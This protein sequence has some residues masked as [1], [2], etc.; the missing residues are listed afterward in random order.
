MHVK[1]TLAPLLTAALAACTVADRGEVA[2]ADVAAARGGHPLSCAS[3]TTLHALATCIGAQM[4]QA[5]SNGFVV[6]TSAQQADFAGVVARM[7]QGS[8]SFTLPASLAGT[9]QLRPFTDHGNGTTYCLFMEVADADDDGYVDR[10][11]GTFIVDP[12]A[13]RELSHQAAHPLSDIGTELQAI[14]IF[15]ETASRSYLMCGADRFA[16]AAASPCEPEAA[17]GNADCAHNTANMFYPATRAIA[18]HYGSQANVQIQWHGIA[19][20]TCP[21]D[22]AY[23]SPGLRTAPATSSNVRTLRASALSFNPSWVLGLSGDGTCDMDGSD[24]TEGRPLN[25][26]PSGSACTTF[27]SSASDAFI[28]I[29][30]HPALRVAASWVPAILEAFPAAPLARPG[31]TGAAW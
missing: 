14:D 15:Q 16:N 23:L 1:S 28:H 25:G 21:T 3:A 7:L 31:L 26:V 5:G 24:N 29:E 8:C 20:S 11:W 6:P 4:P 19:D 27:A 10:G 13:S 9:M 18:A 12:G 17:T 22:S 30:Q 2:G